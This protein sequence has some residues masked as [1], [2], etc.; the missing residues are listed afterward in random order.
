MAGG[1]QAQG[2]AD[3]ATPQTDSSHQPAAEN[4]EQTQPEEEKMDTNQVCI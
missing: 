1:G 4:S 3:A 2:A